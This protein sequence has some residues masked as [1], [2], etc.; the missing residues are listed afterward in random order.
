MVDAEE[1]FAF[2]LADHGFGHYAIAECLGNVVGAAGGGRVSGE[3]ER[4][5]DG[6][7]F[8]ACPAVGPEDGLSGER[9]QRDGVVVAE[10]GG[11]CGHSGVGDR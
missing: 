10:G 9:A 3:V 11:H 7:G 6:L 4:E 5:E 1:S 2:D 8:R